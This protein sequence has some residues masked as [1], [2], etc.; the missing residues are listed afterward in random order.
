MKVI[1]LRGISGSGKSTLKR[2][3]KKICGCYV[4]SFSADDFWGVGAN[5][6]FVASRLKDAH[7]GCLR[8][9]I[10]QVHKWS[11]PIKYHN[12]LIIVDNTNTR[13]AEIAPYYA[14]AKS[15]GARI[16]V[17]TIHCPIELAWDRNVHTTPSLVLWNQYRRLLTEELPSWWDH[18]VAFRV[19]APDPEVDGLMI[20]PAS[21]LED[22]DG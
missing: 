2:K 14:I 6:K 21:I 7:D 8:Q 11:S 20:D 12:P 16:K 10:K 4:A 3:L 9:Y 17:I 1:I 15:H 19:A 18:D 5:Y 13:A 22:M